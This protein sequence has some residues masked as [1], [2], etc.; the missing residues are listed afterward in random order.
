MPDTGAHSR[1]A[2]PTAK[3]RPRTR[4]LLDHIAMHGQNPLDMALAR[5]DSRMLHTVREAIAHGDVLLAFQPVVQAADPDRPAFWEG[6]IRILDT[7]GRVIPARDFIDSVETTELGRQI[8]CLALEL[9]L[10]TLAD[11]PALRLSINMS[12]RSIGYPRWT[13]TLDI[14][15][16]RDPTVAEAINRDHWNPHY[17]KEFR[18][19]E[20]VRATDSLEEALRDKEVVVSVVPCHGVREV[21][22]E[23]ARFIDPGAL[24]P[25]VLQSYF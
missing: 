23:A 4:T 8:D 12:A 10:E 14:G 20:Q 22:T 13:E 11:N 24:P 1:N 17:L 21:W 15:L 16:R 18:L 7:S 25:P 6:L 9:G 5:R 2:R 19:P 3:L